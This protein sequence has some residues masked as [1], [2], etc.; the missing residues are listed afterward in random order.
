MVTLVVA[1]TLLDFALKTK[2]IVINYFN[3]NKLETGE[4]KFKSRRI[5]C[6]NGTYS[7]CIEC[8]GIT[9][10]WLEWFCY[11]LMNICRVLIQI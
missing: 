10:F 6:N 2:R 5:Q 8:N 4:L 9:E 3:F 11:N 7:V 1:Y